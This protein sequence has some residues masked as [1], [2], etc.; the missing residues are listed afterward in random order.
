[1]KNQGSFFT[2]FIS[3][4]LLNLAGIYSYAQKPTSDKSDFN[5]IIANETRTAG[6]VIE[7]DLFLLSMDQSKPIELAT[8]QS[9]I[10]VNPDIYNGGTI[11]ASIVE[12][13]S[14]LIDAQKPIGI[15]FFQSSNIIKVAARMM[16][17][18]SKGK[19]IADHGSIISSKKPGTRVCRIR[20]TNSVSFAHSPVK[21]AFCFE[22][23][24]YPTMVSKYVSGINTPMACNSA[25]CISIASDIPLK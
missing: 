24:P 13:S 22:R 8:V 7:F 11:V 15:M 2:V 25:N 10:F 5:Y 20:L 3:F 23:N 14:E 18:D 21:L 16:K 12:G 6:N 1:M 17:L 19:L 4:L 9:G